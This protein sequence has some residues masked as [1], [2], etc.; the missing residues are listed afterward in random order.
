M[1][2]NEIPLDIDHAKH[3]VGGLGG[4]FFRRFTHVIMAVIPVI[5]FTK[6]EEISDFFSLSP[7]GLVTY[8]CFILI[9][10]EMLRLYFGVIVVGQREYEA[11][12][13]S[14]LA[15]GA[16]AVCLALLI[17]PESNTSN[18]MKSGLYAAPLDM[19]FDIC[20]PNN[21]GNKTFKKKV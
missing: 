1:N 16:F 9:F 11:K 12:Q 5:Y 10:L 19:G 20:R 4:H 13:I 21:G 18:G 6:G 14:A 17:S 3:S 2:E 15:W 7:S 8:A